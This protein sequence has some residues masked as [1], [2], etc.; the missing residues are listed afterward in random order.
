M[1]RAAVSTGMPASASAAATSRSSSPA[2]AR[3][4]EPVQP[5][6]KAASFNTPKVRMASGRW[7][8]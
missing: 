4:E 2:P 7:R 8:M 6:P 1:A 5:K 3:Y